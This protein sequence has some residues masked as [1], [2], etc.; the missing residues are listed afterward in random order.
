MP[1]LFSNHDSAAELEGELND[2]RRVLDGLL[3]TQPQSAPT[4]LGTV[5]K[6]AAQ[7]VP[8][9]GADPIPTATSQNAGILSASQA[10]K[11]GGIEAGA[12]VNV[13]ATDTVAKL[14]VTAAASGTGTISNETYEADTV[15]GNHVL[16]GFESDGDSFDLMV[17]IHCE[18]TDWQP[19]SVSLILG[20]SVIDTVAKSAWTQIDDR[21]FTAVLS[22][23]TGAASGTYFVVATDGAISG[24][25]AFVRGLAPP[26]CL[27]VIFTTHPTN[28]NSDIHYPLAQSQ[29]SQDDTLRIRLVAEAHATHI[30]VDSFEVSDAVQGPFAYSGGVL[31]IDVQVAAGFG[32]TDGS[33][34]TGKVRVYAV[35]GVGSTPGTK[36]LTANSV[37]IDDAVP[38]FSAMTVAYFTAEA[39]KGTGT[40]GDAEVTIT[41]SNTVAGDSI[42]YQDLQGEVK[43]SNTQGGGIDQSTYQAT[44]W[45]RRTSG[46]YR[47]DDDSSNYQLIISRLSRNGRTAARNGVVEIA[48]ATPA[49]TIDVNSTQDGLN[50]ARLRTDDGTLNY[51]DHE[52]RL[53]GDQ[54]HLSTSEPSIVGPPKGSFV[55]GS[56]VKLNDNEWRRDLRVVDLDMLAG[57][58]A[59]NDYAWSASTS[60]TWTNRAGVVQSVTIAVRDAYSLGGFAARVL[61]H[62]VVPDHEMAIS[63]RVVDT[64]KVTA[65][66]NVKDVAQVYEASIQHHN[67]PDPDANNFFTTSDGADNYD[68]DSSEYHDSDK[69]FADSVT[70]G[71]SATITVEETV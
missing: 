44:K 39:L 30:Y 62:T 18:G 34:Q 66:N 70:T 51:V 48:H 20:G 26:L 24:D 19:A 57:G 59:A 14:F 23:V 32:T 15:P 38:L 7:H 42:N 8:P 25:V 33:G 36:L 64:A 5:E 4:G 65:Y 52:I 37:E 16:T 61:A 12:Q 11:L 31:T 46:A 29:A 17:E 35:N 60:F 9:A 21:V 47:D 50:A 49:I 56:W 41:C 3:L 53:Q 63:V 68:A 28:T 67:D 69:R 54:K 13:P 58:Q 27:G 6:H 71:D 10:A 1:N 43:I 55:G 40:D 22:E 45:V 2:M